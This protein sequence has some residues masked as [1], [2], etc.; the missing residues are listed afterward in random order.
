MDGD[1]LVIGAPGYEVNG[2][3]DC[4]A[5]FVFEKSGSVW[6]L[7]D[8]LYPLEPSENSHFGSSVVFDD[9]T[10]L[11]GNP[12]YNSKQG[13]VEIFYRSVSTGP[14]LFFEY[15]TNPTPLSSNEEFGHSLSLS[16]D[17]LSVGIPNHGTD[18]SG[19]VQVWKRPA[20][21]LTFHLTQELETKIEH[22][23]RRFGHAVAI[24]DSVL[25]AGGLVD[26]DEPLKSHAPVQRIVV[27]T[28]STTASASITGSFKVGWYKDGPVTDDIPIDASPTYMKNVLESSLETGLLR[29]SRRGPDVNNG[30]EWTIVFVDKFSAIPL[31]FIENSALRLV[32]DEITGAQVTIN[33]LLVPNNAIK[34]V[35][36]VFERVDETWTEQALLEPQPFEQADLFGSTIAMDGDFVIIGA[37]NRDSANP[38]VNHGAAYVYDT[39]F[40]EYSFSESQYECDEF[41]GDTPITINRSSA[42]V[43][44]YMW[45]STHDGDAWYPL[46][47]KPDSELFSNPAKSHAS[48]L[49][50]SKS[51]DECFWISVA[52]GVNP[53]I[54]D[55]HGISDYAPWTEL[56]SFPT[57]TTSKSVSITITDDERVEVP[58]EVFL[59]KLSSPGIIPMFG[60]KMWSSV[61]IHDDGD[62]GVGSQTTMAKLLPWQNDRTYNPWGVINDSDNH[63]HAGFGESTDM[64]GDIA[65]FGAPFETVDGV[66]SAGKVYIFEKSL[67]FWEELQILTIPVVAST[68]DQF[69]ASVA[70]DGSRV[71]IGSPGKVSVYVYT[72]SG[73]GEEFTL[74]DT[75]IPSVSTN[76]NSQFGAHG[77]IDIDDNVIVVGAAG[78]ESV[79]VYEYHLGSWS[80][81]QSL[82]SSDWMEVNVNGFTETKVSLFGHAVSLQDRT[83]VVGA[84]RSN[85]HDKVNIN[86][87]QSSDE[88]FWGEGRVYVFIRDLDTSDSNGVWSEDETLEPDT[89][90]HAGQFGHSVDVD[91]NAVIVG[92]VAFPTASTTTWSFETG[93][94]TGWQTT[95]TAFNNQPT[96]GDNAY[97]RPEYEN[98][99]KDNKPE[100]SMHAGRYWI[101]TYENRMGDL[102]NED[103]ANYNVP[104]DTFAGQSQGD[105]PIGT[106]ISSPF[107]IMGKSISFM[108]GGGCDVSREYVELLI[109]NK[110][111]F[112]KT[113]QCTEHMERRYWNV[114]PY[115]GQMARI[116]VV[117]AYD[118]EWGHINF[119]DV[120]FDWDLLDEPKMES[121]SAFVFH[122]RNPTTNDPCGVSCTHAGGC[123][124]DADKSNCEWTLEAKLQP[125]DVNGFRFGEEVII[126]ESEEIAIVSAP[127]AQ[128]SDQF[129]NIVE[130]TD[131]AGAV[132][133]FKRTPE[134][135]DAMHQLVSASIWETPTESFRLQAINGKTLDHFHSIALDGQTLVVAAP[136]DDTR[137]IDCGAAYIYDI[138]LHKI[139]FKVEDIKITESHETTYFAVE[140]IREEPHTTTQIISLSTS[141][142][143]GRS[144]TKVNSDLCDALPLSERKA[145]SYCGDLLQS[146]QTVEFKAGYPNTH[147]FLHVINDRSEGDATRTIQLQLFMPGQ[148]PLLGNNHQATL[149][150]DDDDYGK[151]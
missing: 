37:P 87:T 65:V 71:I 100:R 148:P 118:G 117:D 105:K 6:S 94:L 122:R 109:G 43:D 151:A 99:L 49:Q 115:I 141:D 139:S 14:F 114:E 22:T 76:T 39:R 130:G 62:G 84:P 95:G 136:G 52:D 7:R 107:K 103:N 4:G 36:S 16:G 47:S 104:S 149:I 150:I 59:V 129:R 68:N 106:L 91:G 55:F 57:A 108:I 18:S 123:V 12:G 147:V 73:S 51:T 146:T 138:S 85:D 54:Y 89:S 30:Y 131:E 137:N 102:T 46:S 45:F 32:G 93:D 25:V 50:S 67:G 21:G 3:S 2:F 23:R 132:Y 10:L 58:D 41:D 121:G 97:H 5:V 124:T 35:V 133:L 79:F 40:L 44:S 101:G 75:L 64:K 11:V 29:V 77:S 86:R 69:G 143:T 9:L 33:S 31:M 61:L 70:T 78:L 19:I 66:T 27:S 82:R 26:N 120:R 80:M 20:F 112:Q 63:Y 116:R 88:R 72:R 125:S 134:K 83:I 53:S 119:D 13:R 81:V 142:I 127:N 140:L 98:W 8:T 92:G 90:F 111:V 48:C 15:F 34:S 145:S 60:G 42:L 28:S 17:R 96:F 74:E 110:S 128:F 56:L 135:R 38:G 1:F 24:G 113:G 126:S 144:I